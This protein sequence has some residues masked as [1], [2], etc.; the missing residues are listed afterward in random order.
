MFRMTRRGVHRHS[1]H[2]QKEDLPLALKTSAFANEEAPESQSTFFPHLV[3]V[4]PRDT[5]AVVR[6]LYLIFCN[7]KIS[8]LTVDYAVRHL[9]ARVMFS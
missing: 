1:V 7:Q 3:G 8:P 9:R 4:H 6:L 5:S 2:L